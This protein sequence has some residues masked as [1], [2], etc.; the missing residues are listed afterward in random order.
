MYV[1]TTVPYS[2]L[3]LPSILRYVMY[4]EIE[5][6]AILFLQQRRLINNVNTKFPEKTN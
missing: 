3:S 2:A 6:D 4:I 5:V 1:S